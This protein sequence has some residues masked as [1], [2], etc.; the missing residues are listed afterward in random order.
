MLAFKNFGQQKN[1]LRS[2]MVLLVKQPYSGPTTERSQS[3]LSYK[4][5]CN[6]VSS[7]GLQVPSIP[8]LPMDHFVAKL[9]N[10]SR[11]SYKINY[12]KVSTKCG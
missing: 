3:S 10:E 2:N 12:H 7:K 6:K 9:K 8:P 1:K 5:N 4:T 11:L